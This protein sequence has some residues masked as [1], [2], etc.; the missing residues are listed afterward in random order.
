MEWPTFKTFE[1]VFTDR[2]QFEKALK[3]CKS[4]A[5]DIGHCDMIINFTDKS[6]R[7]GTALLLDAEGLSSF[8]LED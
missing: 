5:N 3:M 2:E 8:R 1:I 6:L 7:D 4:T